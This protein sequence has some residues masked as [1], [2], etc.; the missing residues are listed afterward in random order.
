MIPMI[1]MQ[2]GE[3]HR[4]RGKPAE[5]G[6]KIIQRRVELLEQVED[7]CGTQLTLIDV[8]C[9]NGATLLR[10]SN[11]MKECI[12]IDIDKNY[13]RCFSLIMT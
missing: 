5:Y 11:K 1:T 4:P 12:G 13:Q 7:F 10:V 6:H 2:S 8:G 3:R 9:G